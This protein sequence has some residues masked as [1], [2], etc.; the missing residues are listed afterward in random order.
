MFDEKKTSPTDFS[1]RWKEGYASMID[2][3]KEREINK[4]ATLFFLYLIIFFVKIDS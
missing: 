3:V 4:H 2:R 1:L